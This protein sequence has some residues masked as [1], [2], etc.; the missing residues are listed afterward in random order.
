MTC[1]PDDA[2]LETIEKLFPL[3]PD[4]DLTWKLRVEPAPCKGWKPWS[5][6]DVHSWQRRN[7]RRPMS[8][9]TFGVVP[10][11]VLHLLTPPA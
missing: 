2:L 7:P 5:I 10:Y 1:A 4:A 9:R 6:G 11:S 3:Q 8:L